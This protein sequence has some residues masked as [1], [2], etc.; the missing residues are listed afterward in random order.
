[1]NEYKTVREIADSCSLSES[2]IR[3][4]AK[5]GRF[6]SSR[7]AGKILIRMEDFE[8]FIQRFRQRAGQ[9]EKVREIL[10]DL[11]ERKRTA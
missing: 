8:A 11:F 2:T 9:N 5:E 3:K 10:N 7:P 4:W 6:P 1:M